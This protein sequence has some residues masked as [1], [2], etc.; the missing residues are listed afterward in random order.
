MF[1]LKWTL[2]EVQEV[3]ESNSYRVSC[4][5]GTGLSSEVRILTAAMA[6]SSSNFDEIAAA[7]SDYFIIAGFGHA[8]M[9]AIK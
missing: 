3:F 1:E 4:F 9:I 8:F 2:G 7:I 5:T 6:L